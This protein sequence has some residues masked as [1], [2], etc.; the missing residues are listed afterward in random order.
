[1]KLCSKFLVRI[2][3]V[4]LVVLMLFSLLA[5]SM[6]VSGATDTGNVVKVQRTYDVAVVYDNSG[7]M[8]NGD[9][10][11]QAKYSMEIFASMLDYQNGDKL[12]IYPM[13]PVT[14]DPKATTDGTLDPIVIDSKDDLNLI[15]NMYT[16]D[17][18]KTPFVAVTEAYNGLK[19]ST[20]DEKWLLILTD[21]EFTENNRNEKKS[22]SGALKK[23]LFGEALKE[24]LLELASEDIKVQFLYLEP[25]NEKDPKKFEFDS[26][27]E[28]GL[29]FYHAK[30]DDIRERLIEACNDIF[31]RA[32]LKGALNGDQLTLD[33]SMNSLIVFV[34]GNDA[35][36]KS[37]TDE[38]GNPVE[39][40]LNSGQRTWSDRHA[41]LSADRLKNVEYDKTLAG[42]VVTFG[43]CE[44]G[45][46]TLSM[47]G[48]DS[49]N[50]QIFY[51][52]NVNIK[53]VMTDKDG[54]VMDS[55]S[56]AIG[57]GEY[58][59][60]SSIIDSVTGED[61]T[62]NP[63]LGKVSLKTY[64]QNGENGEVKEYD[65]GAKVTLT[66]DEQTNI[67]VEGKYLED[68]TISTKDHPELFPLNWNVAE[69]PKLKVSAK[70]MQNQAWYMPQKHDSWQPIKVTVTN[71]GEKLSATELESL[72]LTPEFS[73]DIS[74][75]IEPLPDESA[76]YIHIAQDKSGNYVEPSTGLYTVK[77]KVTITDENGFTNVGSDTEM[78]EIQKYAK[79]WR[80]LIWIVIIALILL[81]FFLFMSQKVLPKRIDK[82]TADF[83]TM[84]AG[85]LGPNYVGVDYKRKSRSLKVST[86]GAVDFDEKCTATFK[87]QPVDNRFKSSKQRRIKI[88]GINTNCR[89]VSINHT[90]YVKND[91]NVWVKSTMVDLAN[92]P[93]IAHETFCPEIELVRGSDSS[94][95]ATLTCKVKNIK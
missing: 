63:L 23:A 38:E 78:F 71:N 16:T 92:P 87:L 64:V 52:P 36:I 68:Y 21:G 24:K 14:T 57:A 3:S 79:I 42:Q 39:V 72:V 35:E 11:C 59:V 29:Y 12:T 41:A 67:Y 13:W 6:V 55:S 9:M 83:E 51:E 85:N 27:V 37:L 10:W 45:T 93:A 77:T 2:T 70:V 94:T 66:P 40:R 56:G 90:E 91:K 7:S 22:D 84:S 8:Y 20:A 46:Y 31:Q 69:L 48:V 5:A 18:G 47:T 60:T 49:K 1:M 89:A 4:V 19:N 32:E 30:A 74:Y 44:K 50:V 80:W 43:A 58:T 34:Q 81:L 33:M 54:N 73:K 26:A 76:F 88:V 86:I 15:H 61:V 25:K 82:D 17:Y 53:V 28:L 75:R 65:N 95:D 62:D